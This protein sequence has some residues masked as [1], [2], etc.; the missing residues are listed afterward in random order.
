MKREKGENHDP[1][2]SKK[3]AHLGPEPGTSY[4]KARTVPCRP[5]SQPPYADGYV[6][7]YLLTGVYIHSK[8]YL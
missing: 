8:L 6:D 3:R 4:T 5:T 7:G 1:G 2:N